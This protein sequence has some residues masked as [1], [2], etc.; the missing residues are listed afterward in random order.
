MDNSPDPGAT[1][2]IGKEVRRTEDIR[3]ITGKGVY[4]ADNNRP[5]QVYA[6]FVRSPYA[7][8]I[9]KGFEL[10]EALSVDGVLTILTGADVMADNLAPMLHD[11]GL[12]GP[13]AAQM[14]GP[15]IYLENRD[16]TDT[17]I[18][19]HRLLPID[20]A[21]F[22]GEAV[23]MVVAE[24]RSAAQEAAELVRVDYEE[25]PFVVAAADAVGE[26]APAVW[27]ETPGNIVLEAEVGDRAATHAAFARAR[28]VVRLRTV[29]QRASGIPM[30]PRAALAVYD[31]AA[32]HYTLYAGSS[33]V[34]RHKM[35]LSA[36]LAVKPEQVR[37]VAKDVGGNF[38]TRNNFYPELGLLAW[39]SRRVGRPVKWVSTRSE[40]FLT[41][42]QGRDLTVDAEMALDAEGTV[43]GL[44]G[45]N[46]SNVGAYAASFVALRKGIGLMSSVY[47]IPAAH[48]VGRAVFT[49]T[50]PTTPMRS[51]GRP[52]AMFVI[53]RLMDIAARQL[54]I[55]PVDLRRRN[56]IAPD[57]FPYR[58][59]FGLV[60]DNGDY[61]EAMAEAIRL[62]DWHDFSSRRAEARSRGKYRGIGIANYVEITTGPPIE[63]ADITVH[64][65]GFV[66]VAIGTVSSGQGHETSFAQLVSE[67]LSVPLHTVRL[68]AGDTDKLLV[69]GGSVSGRS[70]RFAGVVIG[71]AVAEVIDRSRS[72]A[73]YILG[74]SLDRL[75]HDKGVFYTDDSDVRLDVFDLA[76][77]VRERNDLPDTLRMPL[78]GA[79]QELFT[80]AGF[81]YGSQVCEVEVDPETGQVS[82]ETYTAVDDVG[83]AINP[84]IVHGQTHGG[85]VMGIGQAL[86]EQMYYDPESG[87]LLTGSFMDY[88]M[89]RASEMPF[90]RVGLSET[91]SPSNPLGIRAGGEGGTTP[92][93]AVVVNAVVNALSE[94]GVEHLEM[95]VTSA[96]VWNAIHGR[97][98]HVPHA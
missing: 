90:F 45:T 86:M 57:A 10:V 25:L 18:P 9:I 78:K 63:R 14:K 83:H 32:D 40:C 42:Y 28:H 81:P 71:K 74:V 51:A 29:V 15:D 34:F 31:G 4:S 77:Q 92:A 88:A 26:G 2:L 84:M 38:G 70:M 53:E 66:D 48:F 5:D 87:Q 19:P 44:R 39:A 17:V 23:A 54:G 76:R 49:N 24:T 1:D 7:H 96:C 52:E 75:R 46:T 62:S 98:A 22:N 6:S 73:A 89:P 80:A 11:H 67:W 36:I 68:L 43:L 58:N 94:F 30:E 56:I 12:M 65:D 27:D 91:P 93:L 79:C 72:L 13:K 16:G 3:L 20:R 82:I 59:P 21:R 50:V 41:D 8:A 37:V 55:D 33:G 64:H 35:E 61:A 97:I 69:G 47:D 60:Y 95:P 85:A